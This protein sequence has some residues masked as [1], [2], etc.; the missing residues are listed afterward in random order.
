M[1]TLLYNFHLELFII[2]TQSRLMARVRA[3][4]RERRIG[5]DNSHLRQSVRSH[6]NFIETLRE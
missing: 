2:E 4:V 3:F 6:H 5:F 1:I